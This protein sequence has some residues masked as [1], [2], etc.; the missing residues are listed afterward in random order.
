MKADSRPLGPKDLAGFAV[1][2]K[3]L[4][5]S[6]NAEMGLAYQEGLG[7]MKQS[8]WDKAIRAFDRAFE[9]ANT[10]EQASL[11]CLEGVCHI[12]ADRVEKAA[13][14]FYRSLNLALRAQDPR[15]ALAAKTNAGILLLLE[16]MYKQ[17]R[18]SL[19]ETLEESRRIGYLEGQAKALCGLAA[20]NRIKGNRK[21]AMRLARQAVDTATRD[22]DLA[23]F[24][25][26]FFGA[27]Y[28]DSELSVELGDK[29]LS[30]PGAGPAVDERKLAG[31]ILKA[32]GL[33]RQR[34]FAEAEPL[35]ERAVVQARQLGIGDMERACLGMQCQVLREMQRERETIP[36]L[37]RLYELESALAHGHMWRM[38]AAFLGR[39]LLAAG[40]TE[41]AL[42]LLL[43]S[44]WSAF[45]ADDKKAVGMPLR[46]LV[47]MFQ[48]MGAEAFSA[49]VEEH[50]L[51]RERTD[52]L[53]RLAV[54]GA[55]QLEDNEEPAG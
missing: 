49:A 42:P 3:P 37:E 14:T 53:I 23:V 10:A 40:E 39:E 18:L 47:E 51:S 35:F 33:F 32:E 25:R 19:S 31:L 13:G 17:A 44:F 16:R 34:R 21:E 9:C 52:R 54:L 22:P 55:Q 15:S 7:F 8:E 30:R 48:Q 24:S 6:G 1:Y 50:G 26:L 20:L 41:R 11:L 36:L 46:G 28:D 2:V 12:G 45:D 27:A 43:E 29:L 5:D 38:V 4:T